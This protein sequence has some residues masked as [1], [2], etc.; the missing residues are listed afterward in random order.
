MAAPG[1]CGDIEFGQCDLPA[2]IA[3]LSYT[4]GAAGARRAVLLRSD[5]GA[6]AAATTGSVSATCLRRPP[7]PA[8][9]RLPPGRA[10]QSCSGAMAAPWAA[11][12]ASW[13]V[14]PACADRRLQLPAGRR[15]NAP[16]CP[17]QGRWR[18]RSCG[19]NELGQCDL[20]A[21]I[22]GCCRSAPRSPAQARWRR[23]GVWRLRA[24]SVRP[25]CGDHRPQLHAGCRRR[26]APLSCSG[27]WAAPGRA[28]TTSSVSATCLR[29]SPTSAARRLPPGRATQSCVAAEAAPWGTAATS[30]VSVTCL[31]RSSASAARR[32]PPERATLSCSGALGAPWAAVPTGQSE[33]PAGAD[34]RPQL[35]AGA[36]GARRTV[37]L[38]SDGGVVACGSLKEG[39]RG[40]PVPVADLGYEQAA[41]G[42]RHAVLLRS[43][44]GG[45][46]CGSNE[47]SRGSLAALVA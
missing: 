20:P 11:A 1:G 6:V 34:L 2:P 31:R 15:R 41:V 18:R 28:A 29:R 46:A 21:P 5:G 35:R 40:L 9:R 26:C 13:S 4:Q 43:G 37:L 14:R 38:R 10:K 3:D 12:T 32:W 25:A 33:R 30:S 36:A 45:V 16:L 42:A 47:E 7:T 39:R 19:A 24:R 17:A 22:A 23:R 44:G 8:T 27:A